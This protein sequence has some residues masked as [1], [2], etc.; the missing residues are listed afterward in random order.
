MSRKDTYIISLGGSIV[1]LPEG[2][3]WKFLKEFRGLI[4]KEIRKGKRFF[5]IVGGGATWRKYNEAARQAAKVSQVDLDWL[6]IYSGRLNARLLKTVLG[7]AACPE[8]ITDPTSSLSSRKKIIIGS[9]WKPG[10][11]TDYVAT[12][13]AR[14]HK[15]KTIINLSNIDYVY[16][17]DPKKFKSAKP[18]KKISW[19]GFRKIIGNKWNPG[20]HAP[21]DPVA[22]RLAER[23]D[24]KVIIMNGKKLD[25]LGDYLAGR[26]FMGTVIGN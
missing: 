4:L 1:V 6:G 10:W 3:D 13:M 26:R 9:G 20:L 14:E 2:I 21:F 19:Q 15:I 8:I 5:I 18:I 11:S 24:L 17:G 16:T 23:L 12:V 7:Q 22:S 25:N